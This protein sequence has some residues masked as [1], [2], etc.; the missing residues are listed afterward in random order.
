MNPYHVIT[1]GPGS[2]KSTLIEALRT[3]GHAVVG[4]AGRAIIRDQVARGGDALPW[5]DRVAYAR[6]MLERD[7]AA[8]RAASGRTFFDRGI[9][10]VQGYLRLIGETP[11]PEVEAAVAA[12][13]YAPI[14]FI[15]PPWEAIFGRDAERKQDFDEAIRTCDAMRTVY[16]EAGYALVELPLAPVAERVAFVLE[17]AGTV[18]GL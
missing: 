8:Y 11:L 10:D 16:G 2:G 17:R 3:A 12:C 1:G 5:A 13:R 7:V 18:I 9:P 14:V 6:L 15:A 4:E